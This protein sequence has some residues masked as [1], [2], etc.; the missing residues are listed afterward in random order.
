MR[1]TNLLVMLTLVLSLS[2]FPAVH[3]ASYIFS[4][5]DIP[6]AISTRASGI[7]DRGDIVGE[8]TDARGAHGFIFDGKTVTSIDFP[9][10]RG[11]GV[12][13]INNKGHVVGN[14]TDG[15][16]RSHGFLYKRR[17][18]TVVD[19]PYPGAGDT[20]L[21]GISNRGQIVGESLFINAPT[22]ELSNERGFLYEDQEFQIIPITRPQGI[23]NHGEIVGLNT[24]VEEGLIYSDGILTPLSFPDAMVTTLLTEQ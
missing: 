12:S 17:Q 20:L 18:F 14:F 1:R 5:F 23:N 6:G 15:D 10:S 13:A 2:V 16:F 21:S 7:N 4:N 24:G 22:P 11:T 3:G 8:Y 9:Q 19:A